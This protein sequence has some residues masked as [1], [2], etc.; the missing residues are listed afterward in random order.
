MR[1][2]HCDWSV[3][4]KSDDYIEWET[5][6]WFIYEAAYRGRAGSRN[7]SAMCP[8]CQ[9]TINIVSD[10]SLRKMGDTYAPRVDLL[11]TGMLSL[12]AATVTVFFVIVMV[13]CGL[14]LRATFWLFLWLEIRRISQTKVGVCG[15]I[16]GVYGIT[17][18]KGGLVGVTCH[19]L[20]SWSFLLVVYLHLCSFLVLMLYSKYNITNMHCILFTI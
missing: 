18:L 19:V 13:V 3:K 16:T 11:E 1:L 20:G 12:I 4:F 15:L 8:F 10:N 2:N 9:V 5:Y 14:D 17:M 7:P 6:R